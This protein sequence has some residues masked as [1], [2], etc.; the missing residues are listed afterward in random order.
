VKYKYDTPFRLLILGVLPPG[1]PPPGED[2]IRK[3]SQAMVAVNDPKALAAY[4]R[5]RRALVAPD[6][7]IARVRTPTLGVIGSSDPSLTGMQD[8][9][10][11]MSALSLVVIE[12]AAHGGERGVLRHPQF[13]ATLRE[14]LAA[15]R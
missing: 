12:G 6:A 10:K 9:K 2:E 5:G 15:R 4:H 1:A 14:F 7:K 11:A 13:L 8:M 3:R